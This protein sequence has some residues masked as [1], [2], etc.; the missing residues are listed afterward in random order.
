[1]RR[2]GG[3]STLHQNLARKLARGIIPFVCAIVLMEL[4]SGCGGASTAV[5]TTSTAAADASGAAA[6]TAENR[7]VLYQYSTLNALQAGVYDGYE[8]IGEVEEHGDQGLGTVEA[9]DGE[10]LIVD[11]TAYQITS[12]GK[13]HT[14]DATMLT[15]F[16]VVTYFDHDI[17]LQLKGPMTFAQL[18]AAIDKARASDNLAYAIRIEG[19]FG[20]LKARSVPAQKKPYPPLADVVKIQSEFQFTNVKGTIVGFWLPAYMNGP[21]A[22]GYHMHF[23]TDAR[24]AGGHVLDCQPADVTVY[25]DETAEWVTQLPTQGAFLS[26]NLVQS[27]TE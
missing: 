12:D 6:S 3:S 15:P 21:N 23:I 24:D 19:T 8:T 9:L 17:T 5:Q 16:A 27:K 7:D 26:T 4:L 20:S 18:Q 11:G 2:A 13:V 22:G 10:M 14:P 1:M 25:L